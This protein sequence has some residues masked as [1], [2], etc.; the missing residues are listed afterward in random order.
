MRRA[1]GNGESSLLYIICAYT[2]VPD[3]KQREMNLR[4]INDLE[5]LRSTAADKARWRD[6]ARNDCL[7]L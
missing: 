2:Y 4:N 5:L 7:Q 1:N 3:M 6:K